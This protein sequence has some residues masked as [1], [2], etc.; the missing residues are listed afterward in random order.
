LSSFGIGLELFSY[1]MHR[2]AAQF[3]FTRHPS[4]RDALGDP[5]QEQHNLS[6]R[7]VPGL[8]DGAGVERVG[9]STAFAAPHVE[10][11]TFGLAKQIGILVLGSAVWA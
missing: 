8:E 5:T 10:P 9:L 2:R 7:Q 1:L 4:R 11:A 3:E 6:R